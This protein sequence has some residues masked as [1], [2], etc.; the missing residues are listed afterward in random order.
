M[1]MVDSLKYID[2]RTGREFFKVSS[3]VCFTKAEA[4]PGLKRIG[5]YL[6]RV[7]KQNFF[8]VHLFY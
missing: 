5:L 7:V 4:A 2:R 6:L 8:V 1:A 3:P